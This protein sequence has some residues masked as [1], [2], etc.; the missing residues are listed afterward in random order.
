LPKDPLNE[1]ADNPKAIKLRNA[2]EQRLLVQIRELADRLHELRHEL[3]VSTR[4]R[5]STGRADSSA[6]S[7]TFRR[8]KPR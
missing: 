5:I 6:L 7:K 1:G 2:N 8:R 3:D 4:R